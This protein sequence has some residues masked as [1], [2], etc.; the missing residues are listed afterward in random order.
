MTP[1]TSK[2][3][4]AMSEDDRAALDRFI[5]A[6]SDAKSTADFISG[7]EDRSGKP[8]R[9]IDSMVGLGKLMSKTGIRES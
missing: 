3:L 4:A 6:T 1:E 9:S 2:K 7:M 8:L 5:A